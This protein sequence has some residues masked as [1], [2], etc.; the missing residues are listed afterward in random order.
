MRYVA[1]IDAGGTYTR[2][3][4][5]DEKGCILSAG[6]G[7]P[8]NR[9]FV[10]SVL[11]QRAVERALS[12]ALKPIDKPVGLA[13]VAGPHLPAEAI[14]YVSG[15]V[16]KIIVTDEFEATLA[17]GLQKTGGW[18]AVILSGT[19]S[20]CKG[21]NSKGREKYVGGWGPLIGD[22]GSGYDLAGEA[23]RALVRACDGRGKPTMLTK[24]I[25]SHFGIREAQELK[26]TLYRPSIKRHRFAELAKYV[27][28]AAGKGDAV[29]RG[30]LRNGGRKL[31]KLA[32]PVMQ[33]LFKRNERFP[34]VL[35]GGILFVTSVLSSTL[36][37]E[38]KKGWP[39]ANVFIPELQPVTGAA[40]IA[41]DSIGVK[42]NEEVISNLIQSNRRFRR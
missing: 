3:Q 14:S 30:I 11:A 2:C 8:A 35:S 28:V 26:N 37:A 9:N 42:I 24:L 39:R 36:I 1:G 13:V 22:E 18:G 12:E 19:G 7:G 38:I 17:A 15:R 16:R 34:V 29:A 27:F 6:C 20:F 25:F 31:A 23:L 41:L 10:S 40:I 21:R 33:G 5:A 32:S 4:V